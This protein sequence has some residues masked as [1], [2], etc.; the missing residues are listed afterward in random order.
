MFA[1]T[2]RPEILKRLREKYPPGTE[3][4]LIEMCDPYRKMPPG[5]RGKVTMVD[6]A[7]TVHI[8][9]SNGSTLGAVYGFDTIKKVREKKGD[10][11]NA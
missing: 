4:E 8:A 6:D 3:V 1:V 11:S 9:W 10:Q 5:L 7:G 2:I